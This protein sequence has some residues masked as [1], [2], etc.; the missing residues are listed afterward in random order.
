M[1][2]YPKQTKPRI[3][4]VDVGGMHVKLL[5]TGLKEPIEI[6]SGPTLTAKAMIRKVKAALKDLPYDVVST[7]IRAQSYTDVHCGS[8][9]ISGAAGLGS[10][11]QG[12][13]PSRQDH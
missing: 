7:A 6:L 10:F 9:T 13:W 11:P 2:E 4:V 12:V 8:P 3:L 5:V 1:R